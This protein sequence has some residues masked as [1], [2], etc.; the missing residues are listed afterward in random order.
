MSNRNILVLIRKVSDHF[1]KYHSLHLAFDT[2]HNTRCSLAVPL[3]QNHLG[4]FPFSVQCAKCFSHHALWVI[5][6]Q[7]ICGG[8]S[9]CEVE[10]WPFWFPGPDTFISST[11]EVEEFGT[12]QYFIGIKA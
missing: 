4:V 2:I 1:R 9:T 11:Y 6:H 10:G 7:D 8:I 3:L 5:P 12:L